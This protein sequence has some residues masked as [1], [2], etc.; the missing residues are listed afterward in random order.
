MGHTRDDGRSKACVG[1][2]HGRIFVLIDHS[3]IQIDGHFDIFT[4]VV[5]L[6]HSSHLLQSLS[7]MKTEGHVRAPTP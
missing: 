5:V 1:Y 4:C 7:T 2:I 6:L 3:N